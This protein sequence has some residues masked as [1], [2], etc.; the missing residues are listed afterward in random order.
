[1]SG[2]VTG[3]T[4][5][6]P[7]P[8]LIRKLSV[9][10]A[11]YELK[12][13]VLGAISE[14]H[15]CDTCGRR[16][17]DCPG[18]MGHIELASPVFHYGY[19]TTVCTILRCLH[20]HTGRL[21]LPATESLKEE[22]R[23]L[24]SARIH[25]LAS[26]S[27]ATRLRT[28]SQ[29]CTTRDVQPYRVV[30]GRLFLDRAE[31]SAGDA[32]STLEQITDAEAAMLGFGQDRPEWLILTVLPIPPPQMRPTVQLG[33]ERAEDDLTRKLHEII[34][35]N[36]R[37]GRA[38]ITGAPT[39]EHLQNLQ[40]HVTTFFD[41]EKKGMQVAQQRTGRPM[42]SISHRLKGKEGRFRGN[43]MGKRGDWSARSVITGD[44][45]LS[46]DQLG[47]PVSMARTLTIP[48][49]VN[50]L[51]LDRLQ[52]LVDSGAA[53]YVKAV[54]G[55]VKSVTFSRPRLGLGDIVERHLQDGDICVFN[56]QP[57]L[58]KGSMLAFGAKVLPFSTLRIGLA[59]TPSFNADFDGDE[60]NVF[61]PQTVEARTEAGLLLRAS[62][63]I[64]SPQAHKPVFAIVQ[65]SLLGAYAMTR[66][67]CFLT[68]AEVSS[69]LMA[70]P[71]WDGTVPP[72]T[73]LKPTKLW[74][75]KQLF[76]SVLPKLD[77]DK[78]CGWFRDDQDTVDMST[79]DGVVCMRQG[80]L[81]AGALCKKSLG[82]TDNGL[83]HRAWRELGNQR[84]AAMMDG[85]QWMA[86]AF[87]ELRGFSVG[88]GDALTDCATAASVAHIRKDAKAVTGCEMDI[89]IALNEA[90]DTAGKLVQ[91]AL[92]NRNNLLWMVQAGSKG[93]FINI[94]Q[95]SA[96]V[97]QQNVEGARIPLTFQGRTLPH[98]DNALQPESRGFVDSSYYKGLRPEEM[99]FH[100]VGGREGLIDTAIKT[101]SS[102]YLQRRL[103]K[104]LENVAVA[105]DGTVR[106]SLGGIVQ[107]LYGEDGVSGE[108]LRTV[109]G[110]LL[111]FD[112]TDCLSF[113]VPTMAEEVA[114]PE[115]KGACL[116]H[117]RKSVLASDKLWQQVEAVCLRSATMTAS[118]L[119]HF[120]EQ[121]AN[122]CADALVVPGETVGMI[123]A[124]SMASSVTQS[125]L[126]SFHAAGQSCKS[127]TL[128]V[129]RLT[130]LIGATPNI[131]TPSLTIPTS[132]PHAVKD[133]ISACLLR[134][135][136]TCT[137]IHYDPDFSVDEAHVREYLDWPDV[138]LD[139]QSQWLLRFML[140]RHAV[141]T[142]GVTLANIAEA[143]VQPHV[144][145]YASDQNCDLLVIHLR[146]LAGQDG[147][148][149]T[150]ENA[151]LS[152][153]IRGIPGI[154]KA[155]VREAPG[156][157]PAVETDGSRLAAVLGLWGLQGGNR[158]T[159]NS[160][161]EVL[162]V[163]GIEAARAQ[164]LAEI[165]KVLEFD[166]NY[167]SLRHLLLLVDLMTTSGATTPIT[168]TGVIKQITGP[169]GTAT[170]EETTE[171]LFRAASQHTYDDLSGASQRII[172][173]E[174]GKYGTGCVDLFL[175]EAAL[176]CDD[177]ALLKSDDAALQY[178]PPSPAHCRSLYTPPSPPPA[179]T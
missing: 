154:D 5:S 141:T 118:G 11:T 35:A 19:L 79:T 4:L 102:G 85:V 112:P 178:V 44:P 153:V 144:A 148:M 89:N 10:N 92:P 32:R 132:N 36:D 54:D 74:T 114:T 13:F 14:C 164:L 24:Y 39:A 23:E 158:V 117:L 126:N 55:R 22:A 53:N 168:R 94:S 149:S 121:V 129:P 122:R 170:F 173:G 83:I 115:A 104:A 86:N 151:C 111:P 45:S 139:S 81:L 135:V 71:V 61:V 50:G 179:L 88:I 119:A 159:S 146:Y 123:A 90:R 157:Q 107:F 46:L 98:Y 7:N 49:M 91:A 172:F 66:R 163:L 78:R 37:L 130:E 58:H 128:G 125:T 110:Q 31:V 174:T 21:A 124:L 161:V 116:S 52:H 95:I 38:K 77:Y 70:V 75:G 109:Q 84:T 99:F 12:D 152:T 177:A 2:R 41:N 160:V 80:C 73:I 69:L 101:S 57:S 162:E 56:R 9:S 25:S 93:S 171:V 97:G 33:G 127:V 137:E 87:L 113:R 134:D 142:A 8:N 3:L 15:L 60:M 20:R 47:V 27:P 67:D 175:D 140:D 18:H 133:D 6:I 48:E 59:C 165:R 147:C 156:E 100:A 30:N 76:S 29:M 131:S 65:D 28:V 176:G 51:N 155:Y 105:Y 103:V 166:G 120:A 26:T 167:V 42:Q 136:V 108:C 64:V 43:L 72:P 169:L 96:C 143:L 17:G 40:V 16:G 62:H 68:R 138:P 150:L 1:M 106:T 82:A 34:K 63:N 145:V